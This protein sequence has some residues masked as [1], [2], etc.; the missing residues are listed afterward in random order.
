MPTLWSGAARADAGLSVR[1]LVQR[2]DMSASTIARIESGQVEPTFGMMRQILEAAGQDL[3]SRRSADQPVR[4]PPTRAPGTRIAD[5][6]TA[7]KRAAYRDTP[8]RGWREGLSI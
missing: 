8:R 6:A 3:P 7:W 1:A 4:L 2:A 5:L